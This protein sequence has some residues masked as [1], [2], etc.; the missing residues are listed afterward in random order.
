VYGQCCWMCCGES[1]A[2]L[3]R[4]DGQRVHVGSAG[5]P[6]HLRALVQRRA[7]RSHVIDKDHARAVKARAA[8]DKGRQHERVANVRVTRRRVQPHLRARRAHAPQRVDGRTMETVG[9]I[10][11]LIESAPQP[12]PRMQR[13]RHDAIAVL[14]HRSPGL[15]HQARQRNGERP[16]SFV[17][18]HVND[19]AERPVVASG[20]QADADVRAGPGCERG[21]KDAAQADGADAAARR[22]IKRRVTGGA[23]GRERRGEKGVYTGSEN[24]CRAALPQRRSRS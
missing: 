7:C 4:G 10:A 24:S 23:L 11:G 5:A 19:V 2:R 8:G 6:Q 12:P 14:E 17:L 18:E 1:R 20:G 22:R 21:R 13:D 9:E 16:P 15:A 3:R